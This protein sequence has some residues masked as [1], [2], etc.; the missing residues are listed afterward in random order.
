[1]SLSG[2]SVEKKSK[3]SGGTRFKSGWTLPENIT[4]SAKS[5]KFAYCKLCLRGHVKTIFGK[6]NVI[7]TG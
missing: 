7:V 3:T 2:P 6:I 1:M 5:N 4:S